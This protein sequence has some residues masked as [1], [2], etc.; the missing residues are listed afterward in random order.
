MQVSCYLLYYYI[1][2]RIVIGSQKN[3][4][5]KH[6]SIIVERKSQ[7]VEKE[8]VDPESNSQVTVPEVPRKDQGVETK[9]G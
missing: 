3:E 5:G 8:K 4:V 6:A 1:Y 7:A 9:S 2:H